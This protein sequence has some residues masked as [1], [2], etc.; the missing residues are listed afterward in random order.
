VLKDIAQFAGATA[1]ACAH[2]S[3]DPTH[4]DT[5]LECTQPPQPDD[6]L[7]ANHRITCGNVDSLCYYCFLQHPIT[8]L[9]TLNGGSLMCEIS[10]C[11]NVAVKNGRCLHHYQSLCC[12]SPPCYEVRREVNVDDLCRYCIKHEKCDIPKCKV[13]AG[14]SGRCDF[15]ALF[16]CTAIN[17]NGV[18]CVDRR[19]RWIPT[20]DPHLHHSATTLCCSHRQEE[21][22]AMRTK[23][24][25][26]L[27]KIERKR[28]EMELKEKQHEITLEKKRQALQLGQ[29]D[30]YEPMIV[31]REVDRKKLLFLFH[32]CMKKYSVSLDRKEQ[33][34]KEICRMIDVMPNDASYKTKNKKRKLNQ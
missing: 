27:L 17:V 29:E 28:M 6:V 21:A 13:N 24:E 8:V 23:Y 5:I 3:P 22:E 11:T 19:V 15:H 34:K 30:G 9:R 12:K 26:E 20:Q 14:S 7:C 10:I 25:F 1:M 18:R 4:L 33:F 2:R 31:T 16:H 32:F